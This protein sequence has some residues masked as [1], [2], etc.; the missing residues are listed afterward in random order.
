MN[1]NWVFLAPRLIRLV[2][3]SIRD[4]LDRSVSASDLNRFL[5]DRIDTGLYAKRIDTDRWGNKKIDPGSIRD[6]S[7]S[8]FSIGPDRYA[9]RFGS[10]WIDLDRFGSIWIDLD[11]D[12]NRSES[13]RTPVRPKSIRDRS[14]SI[15]DFYRS[16]SI[17]IDPIDPDRSWFIPKID[18]D[19]WIDF[20]LP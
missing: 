4:D 17:R 18:F 14:R 13:I 10:I 2:R 20:F 8:I 6:R 5:S 19:R 16:E 12:P 3:K 7:K 1:Q 15:I 11:L 9:K